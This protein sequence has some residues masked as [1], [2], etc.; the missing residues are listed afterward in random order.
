[1]AYA[2]VLVELN[3]DS[4]IPKDLVTNTWHFV[5]PGSVA[6]AEPDITANLDA[7]YTAIQTYLSASLTGTATAKYYDLEDPEPRAPVATGAITFTPGSNQLPNEV[8]V[9]MSYQGPI[10]S[11]QNQA[12]RRGRLFLGPL[13]QTGFTG[14]TGEFRPGSAMRSA[15][16]T[17]AD[18]LMSDTSLPGLVWA[19]F[20]P[21]T[22]GPP[23]WSG[24]T[25]ADAFVTITNGWVDDAAD[26][27]RSRGLSPTTRSVWS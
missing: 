10:V 8:A 9:C 19:L 13:S 3:N 27:V 17:A 4:L 18:A 20:S 12:R 25:L 26:T 7:F 5:T 1:M 15:I 24:A 16:C 22:A 11:G 2:R 23:P 14:A 21:S 6:A